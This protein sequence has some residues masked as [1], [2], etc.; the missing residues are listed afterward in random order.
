MDLLF[1]SRTG[2]HLAHHYYQ[3]HHPSRPFSLRRLQETRKRVYEDIQ[4][5]RISVGRLLCLPR[6]PARGEEGKDPP[7]NFS[8]TALRGFVSEEEE[9]SLVEGLHSQR[10]WR[11]LAERSLLF[12]EV[13]ELLTQ[14]DFFTGLINSKKYIILLLLSYFEEMHYLSVVHGRD[15]SGT[16]PYSI[17]AENSKRRDHIKVLD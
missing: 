5:S 7:F 10:A 4:D 11:G 9:D 15:V 14:N 6:L 2:Q 1:F 13:L 17:R 12:K 8:L 16:E 3:L